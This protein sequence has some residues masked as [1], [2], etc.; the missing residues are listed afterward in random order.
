MIT[1]IED[2]FSKGC[3]RC[4]RFATSDCSTRRWSDGLA[5]LRQICLCMK[6]LET[7]KWGHP[8][9]MH[10]NRNVVILGALRNDFRLSFFDAALM[11]DPNGVLERQGPNTQHA[12]MIRFTNNDQVAKMKPIIE[13]YLVEA[14]GYAD[15]G[16]KPPKRESELQVPAELLEVFESDP[17]LAGAFYGLT[18]GRQ[19]SYLINLSS[20]KKAE[21][22]MSRISKFRDKILAGKGAMER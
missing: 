14:I 22:R 9:Y 4:E 8:C 17:E 20:A 12:D 19:R 3:G 1:D 21:T 7:V 5:K 13:S 11:K 2:F 16:I 18:P 6:L 15:K 10:G